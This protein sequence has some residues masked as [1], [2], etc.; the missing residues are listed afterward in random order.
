MINRAGAF[1][2]LTA[3]FPVEVVEAGLAPDGAFVAKLA[4]KTVDLLPPIVSE[5]RLPADV[6]AAL[7]GTP[8]GLQAALEDLFLEV[9][10]R[11]VLEAAGRGVLVERGNASTVLAPGPEAAVACCPSTLGVQ[12]GTHRFDP[13]AA[14]A[15]IPPPPPT[16]PGLGEG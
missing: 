14:V 5:V 9:A 10:L 8:E 1:G 7:D 11:D 16:K 4:V 15:P 6:Y 3:E 2:L 13:S 12:G